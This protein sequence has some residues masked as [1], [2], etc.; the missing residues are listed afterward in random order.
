MWTGHTWPAAP[1]RDSVVTAMGGV[2]C[3]YIEGPRVS[4][5]AK[6]LRDG[7]G[8]ADTVPA[9]QRTLECSRLPA[10]PHPSPSAA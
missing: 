5:S 9:T 4:V 2:C 7:Q 3:L 10:R 6:A 8:R 1:L